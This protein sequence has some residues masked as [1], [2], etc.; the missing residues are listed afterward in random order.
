MQKDHFHIIFLS[1]EDA[2]VCIIGPFKQRPSFLVPCWK[3][4]CSLNRTRL[5][6]VLQGCSF[7]ACSW[8]QTAWLSIPEQAPQRW[9]KVKEA[10]EFSEKAFLPNDDLASQTTFMGSK[11]TLTTFD[12][13][14]SGWEPCA[15]PSWSH[16]SGL[17]YTFSG[18]LTP[19]VQH[20]RRREAEVLPASQ[21]G[22]EN[23]VTGISQFVANAFSVWVSVQSLINSTHN[24]SKIWPAEPERFT[25]CPFTEKVCQLLD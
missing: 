17:G 14:K 6:S 11:T 20:R 24:S 7:P 8:G 9:N 13:K 22:P 23:Q 16:S 10:W 25:L 3:D 1:S 5:C 19:G 2:E 4:D 12:S 21:K 15:F 18:W